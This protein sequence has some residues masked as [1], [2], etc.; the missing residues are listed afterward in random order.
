VIETRH[1]GRLAYHLGRG[2]GRGQKAPWQ[3]LKVLKKICP[4][5][6]FFSLAGLKGTFISKAKAHSASVFIIVCSTI[7][8]LF[9]VF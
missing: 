8:L 4:E 3:Q 2:C 6:F 9:F 5:M 7:V 1:W